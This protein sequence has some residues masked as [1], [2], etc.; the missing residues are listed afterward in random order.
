MVSGNAGVTGWSTCSNGLICNCMN[1]KT[2][3]FQHGNAAVCSYTCCEHSSCSLTFCLCSCQTQQN[4]LML[5]TDILCCCCCC[6][7]C[8]W[9]SQHVPLHFVPH[10]VYGKPIQC[11]LST[12]GQPVKVLMGVP[13]ALP[14][15]LC[16]SGHAQMPPLLTLSCVLTKH[17]FL[18]YSYSMSQICFIAAGGIIGLSGQVGLPKLCLQFS[19]TKR[20]MVAQS[21]CEARDTRSVS[22]YK[23]SDVGWDR[24]IAAGE[25]FD[26]SHSS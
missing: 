6:C 3:G 24:I 9:R 1:R 12:W 5:V 22:S 2:G 21:R 4:S 23:D 17:F 10:E 11:S 14:H 7:C 20:V 26:L 19:Q 18:L 16:Q 25:N 15:P 8:A 13:F